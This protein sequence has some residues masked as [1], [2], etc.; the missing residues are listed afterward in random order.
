MGVRFVSINDG[1]DSNST[2]SHNEG[3]IIALKALVHD[4]HIKDISR[5]IHDSIKAQR[6]RGEYRRGYAPFGYQKIKGQKGK[7][8]PDHA[9][10][11][12]VQRIFECR[13][14]GMGY[15]TICKMLDDEGILT[16][17]EYI[18]RKTGAFTGDYFKS[19]I[20]RPQ[21][22]KTLLANI[23]YIGNLQQ[24]TQVQRL[25]ANEP[26]VDIPRDQWFITENAHE[27]II[28]RELFD[29]VQAI[30]IAGKV[31]NAKSANRPIRTENIFKG[32]TVCGVCGSKMARH[33]SSKKMLH[34]DPW[35]RYY[36]KCP[37]GRQH[38]LSEDAVAKEFRSIPEDILINIVFPLVV[39]ELNKVTKIANIIEK[40]TKHQ[41]NPRDL[42]NKEIT[43]TSNELTTIN[44]RIA[45]LYEDYV[46]K[47]LNEREYVALK[48][49]YE[50]RAKT[51]CQHINNLSERLAI[52]VDVSAS[53]N[54]WLK[55]V[56]EF[57]NPKKL[58]REMLETLVDKILIFSTS[59]V[60]VVW[61]FGDEL[62]LLESIAS[63]ESTDNAETPKNEG[64]RTA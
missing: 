61:K 44:Q 13:A 55:A 40:R 49:K 2:G 41:E 31:A 29:K 42:L 45:K 48:A 64:G 63:L 3:L 27:P 26:C 34:K 25:Y 36:F 15:H 21:V 59:Q 22:L 60:E 39:K 56:R 52:V 16:P 53:N 58:T 35:E 17:N 30:E 37:I 12:I 50:D 20:W 24:G 14:S 8:E 19:T 5:K 57:Q 4:Q 11:P 51:L 6:E 28:S 9:T 46:D 32:F 7:L 43:R 10:A 54:H 38:K 47:L 23:A 62:R 18:R 1:Y 33:Y